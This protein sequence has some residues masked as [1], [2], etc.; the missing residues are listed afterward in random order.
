MP[1]T[2]VITRAIFLYLTHNFQNP[3]LHV[4]NTKNVIFGAFKQS[5]T[6]SLITPVIVGYGVRDLQKMS[7][8]YPFCF[9]GFIYSVSY[10]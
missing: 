7:V 3:V 1:I 6:I 5:K 9:S 10:K 4:E 8:D 2:N